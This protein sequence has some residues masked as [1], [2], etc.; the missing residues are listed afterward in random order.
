MKSNSLKEKRK[1]KRVKLLYYLE[2]L[3]YE[4]GKPLGNLGDISNGG[5]MMLGEEQIEAGKEFLLRMVLPE[6]KFGKKTIT[7]KANSCWSKVDANSTFYSSGYEF[8]EIGPV[9]KS[10]LEFL[11]NNFCFKEN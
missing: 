7:F 3:D 1:H 11:I 5:L 6:K 4:T 9:E 2:I 10:T 8:V